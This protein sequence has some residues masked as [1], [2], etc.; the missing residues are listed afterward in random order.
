MCGFSFISAGARRAFI[1][2]PQCTCDGFINVRFDFGRASRNDL[3]DL[4]ADVPA[5]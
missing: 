1:P 5:T 3:E 4:R 2:T